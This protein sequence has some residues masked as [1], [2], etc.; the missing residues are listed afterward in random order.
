[1]IF[2]LFAGLAY[3]VTLLMVGRYGATKFKKNLIYEKGGYGHT[4]SRLQDV[5]TT[6]NIDVLLLG[7]SHTYRGFD[8]RI[9]ASHGIRAFNLGSSAQSPVQTRMLVNTYIDQLNPKLVIYDVS[10]STFISDGVEASLDLLAN[11]PSINTEAVVMASRVNSIKT[12]NTLVFSAMNSW[13]FSDTEMEEP[14]KKGAHTYHPGG[15]YVAKSLTFNRYG[16][17]G[18]RYWQLRD[19]QKESFEAILT[20]LQQKDIP[21]VL[22]RT[23]ITSY[24]YETFRNNKEVNA[25]FATKGPFYDFN[26]SMK[27]DD[28]LHFYDAHHM[29]QLGVDRFTNTIIDSIQTNNTAWSWQD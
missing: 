28:S 26:N 8:T 2:C 7:S 15:G 20:L 25:Y 11:A 19:S 21:F 5:D 1:M 24:R 4:Y 18:K 22:V 16:M 12:W 13:L 27:L 9:F 14:V 10:P 23:P 6:Q 3:C 17:P 29:N